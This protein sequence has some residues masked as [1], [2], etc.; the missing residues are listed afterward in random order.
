MGGDVMMD[1]WIWSE[2]FGHSAEESGLIAIFCRS[3]AQ[4]SGDTARVMRSIKRSDERRMDVCAAL[5]S[6]SDFKA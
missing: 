4:L 3:Q 6:K 2:I 1:E 5:L